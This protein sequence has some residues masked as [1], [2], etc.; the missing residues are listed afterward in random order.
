MASFT[1]PLIAQHLQKDIWRLYLPLIYLS[2]LPD[3]G[4][5]VVPSGFITDYESVSRWL[6]IL[7]AW[8]RGT[9]PEA[10]VVHDYAYRKGTQFS[11]ETADALLY[12]A[13]LARGADQA[14]ASALWA[15]V[16]LGGWRYYQDEPRQ[17]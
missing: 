1:T 10:A 8:L 16:R 11:R 7:Y 5:V 15:G 6:P 14:R 4:F 3:V 2:D 12:E 13:A 17:P 9:A